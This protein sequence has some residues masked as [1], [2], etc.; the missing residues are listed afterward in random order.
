MENFNHST[1]LKK[2]VHCRDGIVKLLLGTKEL[3]RMRRLQRLKQ[4]ASFTDA[5]TPAATL[6]LIQTLTRLEK[7]L[8]HKIRVY[9]KWATRHGGEFLVDFSKFIL[10]T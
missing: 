4:E 7:F 8:N 2:C 1:T 9:K 3:S 5:L 10:F 6:I